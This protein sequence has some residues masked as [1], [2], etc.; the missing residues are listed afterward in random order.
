[1]IKLTKREYEILQRA[2]M[3]N[4]DIANE[5]ALTEGTV[6]NHF[7]SIFIKLGATNRAEAVIVAIRKRVLDVYSFKI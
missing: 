4:C 7:R 1:M 2:G 6:A 3:S 5:L